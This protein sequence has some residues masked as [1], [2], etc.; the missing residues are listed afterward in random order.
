MQPACTSR[1]VLET[2]AVVVAEY[3][4]HLEHEIAQMKGL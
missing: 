3:A 1:D 2:G 4:L